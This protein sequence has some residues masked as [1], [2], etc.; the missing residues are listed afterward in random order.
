MRVLTNAFSANKT[1]DGKDLYLKIH[2][3]K[4]IVPPLG[5]HEFIFTIPYNEA[6][7]Q[8]AEIFVNILSQTDMTIKHPVAGVLEQYGFD[9]CM[10]E[11]IYKRQAQYASR[12][13]QGLQISAVCK[14]TEN[15]DQEMGV[16]FILHEVR[17]M[18]DE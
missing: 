3:M 10:G 18:T 4:A 1:E 12:L 6:Y 7:L 15:V 9:V 13:P 16:N 2:G 11:V 8:G 17:D 14:N 5:E